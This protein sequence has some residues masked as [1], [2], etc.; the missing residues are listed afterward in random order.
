[1][2]IFFTM[3]IR[4]KTFL[5]ICILFKEGKNGGESATRKEKEREHL[6]IPCL[7]FLTSRNHNMSSQK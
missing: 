5:K 7:D 3:R 4:H 6:Y 1:M 2:N